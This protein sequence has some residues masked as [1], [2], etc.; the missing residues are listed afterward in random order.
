MTGQKKIFI[1]PK[2][3]RSQKPLQS[4][5]SSSQATRVELYAQYQP[6]ITQYC[7]FCKTPHNQSP[8]PEQA[9][10]CKECNSPLFPP[11]DNFANQSRRDL[12]R[13]SSDGLLKV[14]ADWPG[15]SRL[16]RICDLSPTGVRIQSKYLLEKGTVLKLDGENFKAVGEVSYTD[17][18]GQDYLAGLRF[19][20]VHFL[21]QKGQ[22]FSSR[23]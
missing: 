12:N 4:T 11:A 19:L 10:L 18:A 17:T 13:V 15:P 9:P 5:R 2:L 8:C 6:V 16:D 3:N 21:S 14:Y 20:A 1:I 22:F 7:Y 23:I